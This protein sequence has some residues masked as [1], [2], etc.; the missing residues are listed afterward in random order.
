MDDESAT[1]A[2]NELF[3]INKEVNHQ[4]LKY[5]TTLQILWTRC[6]LEE[7]GIRAQI[8]QDNMSTILLA[9]NGRMSSSKHTRHINMRYFFS[10]DKITNKKFKVLYCPIVQM[11]ADMFTKPLEGSLFK[12]FRAEIMNVQKDA[13]L[14]HCV[15][16]LHRSV[17][18][19]YSKYTTFR[20]KGSDNL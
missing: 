3:T 11:A 2:A 10:N 1:P 4:S 14:S 7:K 18:R 17:L 8:Y 5:F 20:A 16:M 9:K 12:K 15:T 6:F 19:K 13:F